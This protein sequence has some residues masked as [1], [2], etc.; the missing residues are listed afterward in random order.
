MNRFSYLLFASGTALLLVSCGGSDVQIAAVNIAP[1][2]NAVE[3][4]TTQGLPVSGLLEGTDA[5]GDALTFS[6]D[7]STPNL[8]KGDMVLDDENTGR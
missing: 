1:V 5:D 4:T 6:I 7:L 8:S 3:V 2:A